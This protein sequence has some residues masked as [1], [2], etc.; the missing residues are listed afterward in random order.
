MSFFLCC[1]CAEKEVA[2]ASSKREKK[3]QVFSPAELEPLNTPFLPSQNYNDN[4]ADNNDS[5]SYQ[6]RCQRR[7]PVVVPSVGPVCFTMSG[8]AKK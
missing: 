4:N 6:K 1:W 7:Y 5:F 3:Y 2:A 8:M